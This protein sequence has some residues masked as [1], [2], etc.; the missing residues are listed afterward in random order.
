[1]TIKIKDVVINTDRF[2]YATIGLTSVQVWM[3]GLP[4][5]R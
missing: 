2:I 3:E 5:T 1:M 4:N